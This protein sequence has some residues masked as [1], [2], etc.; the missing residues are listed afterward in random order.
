M[1]N[2]LICTEPCADDFQVMPWTPEARA[3]FTE[4]FPGSDL[5]ALLVSETAICR[6]CQQL[7]PEE[8]RVWAA[9][10]LMRFLSEFLP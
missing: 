9:Q 7:T 6:R 1:P 3:L 8:K 10:A 5:D 2:C 4:K